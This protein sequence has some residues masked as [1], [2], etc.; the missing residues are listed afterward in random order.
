[1]LALIWGY[2]WVVLKVATHDA[3]AVTVAALRALLGSLCLFVALAVMR[4]PLRP[5]PLGP[6][7][8]LGLLQTT[9]LTLLQTLAVATGGAGKTAILAYTMPFWTVLFAWPYLGERIRTNGAVALALAALGLVL[10]VWPV[11]I[12]G[13]LESECCAIGAAIVWAA[14]AVYAKRMR[15]RHAVDLLGLT[16]W[17]LFL[18]ALPLVAIALIEPGHVLRLTPSFGWAIAYIAVPASAVGWLLWLFILSRLSAGVAGV[19]SLLTPVIGAGA[20]WL[21]L[22]ETPGPREL[23]GLACIVVAIGVNMTPIG[24]PGERAAA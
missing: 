23:A 6:T 9:G 19:A 11:S 2:N 7:L 20:A 5:P 14:S 16:T 10:V 1:M 15:A 4:R 22:G 12:S 3:D 17:Q 8:V 13:G 24:R 18:G 21:Q